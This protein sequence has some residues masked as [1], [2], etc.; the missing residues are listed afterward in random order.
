[1]LFRTINDVRQSL[2]L[3]N[4]PWGDKPWLP[5]NWSQVDS[6]INEERGTRN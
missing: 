2:G 1:L 5:A 3:A 4:V 6:S